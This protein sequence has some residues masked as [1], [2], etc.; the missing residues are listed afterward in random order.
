M[1]FVVSKWPDHNVV[2]LSLFSARVCQ[3]F[4]VALRKL[5]AASCSAE[6]PDWWTE[7]DYA[8]IFSNLLKMRANF[9]GLHTYN[10]NE[11]TNWIGPV[12]HVMANGSVTAA[13]PGA[14]FATS[15]VGLI[16]L[17]PRHPVSNIIVLLWCRCPV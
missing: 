2:A 6:G 13:T 3:C 17:G 12:S 10:F 8:A 4:A 15:A 16:L 1:T 7:D 11:L 9:I 5:R 14:S